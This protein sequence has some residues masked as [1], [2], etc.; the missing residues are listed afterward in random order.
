MKNDKN[1]LPYLVTFTQKR[2]TAT[3][4]PSAIGKDFTVIGFRHHSLSYTDRHGKVIEVE[5]P[6]KDFVINMLGRSNG[7]CT[8]YVRPCPKTGALTVYLATRFLGEWRLFGN[9]PSSSTAV[10]DHMYWAELLSNRQ[11]RV[12]VLKDP[13]PTEGTM[14]L[15]LTWYGDQIDG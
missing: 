9:I 8:A 12:S 2:V 4:V 1:G 13:N 15:E 10:S 5:K 14:R 11:F 3:P 7:L 6:T